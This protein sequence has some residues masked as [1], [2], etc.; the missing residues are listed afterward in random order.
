MHVRLKSCYFT[1]LD[2][3]T[4]AT[5]TAIPTTTPTN[6]ATSATAT[7]AAT[8]GNSGLRMR[9]L[10]SPLLGAGA[11]GMYS[12]L[13]VAAAVEALAEYGTTTNN[14]NNTNNT[15]NNNNTTTNTTATTIGAAGDAASDCIAALTLSDVN[16][17]SDGTGS[18]ASSRG[19]SRDLAGLVLRFGV[20][21]DSLADAFKACFERELE[22]G[23]EGE[24]GRVWEELD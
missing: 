12:A 17:N 15:T 10:A 23:R 9:N 19:R 24:G 18:S 21:D 4:A 6:I 5:V 16:S 11:R 2:I 7:A 20:I 13:A 14:T 8:G 22:G 3:A 1:A